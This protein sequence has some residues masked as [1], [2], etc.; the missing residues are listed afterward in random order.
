M[1]KEE[2]IKYLAA[3]L[4]L[5]KEKSLICAIHQNEMRKTAVWHTLLLGT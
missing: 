2:L 1:A 3:A 5:T 4:G